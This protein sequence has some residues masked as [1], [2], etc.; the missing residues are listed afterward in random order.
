MNKQYQSVGIVAFVLLG[1]W[2]MESC[3]STQKTT[4]SISVNPVHQ[5]LAPDSVGSIDMNVTFGIPQRYISR[6]SR[7]LITPQLII[8]DTLCREFEPLVV[9][10]PVYAKKQKRRAD[11]DGYQDPY[12]QYRQ[13]VETV[14][15]PFE[16]NYH[17]RFNIPEDT[18]N[19]FVCAVVR[20][21]GCGRCAAL[22][23]L[24]IADISNPVTLIDPIESLDLS[25]I[26]PKFVIRPKLREG[27][28]EALLQFIIN[29]YDINLALGN[30]RRE[31]ERMIRTLEPILTDT[32]A[33]IRTLDIY[34]MASADGP[35]AFNTT[36]ARNRALSAKNWL[37]EELQLKPEIRKLI[38]TD[39]RP[40]GWW[41]VYWAMVADGHSDSLAVKQILT[42]YVQ[43]ND[44]VQEHYIRRL[45]CWP[46]IRRKYLSKDRKVEYTYSYTL[47]SF[48]TDDELKTMYRIRPDAFNEDELLRV[49]VLAESD[50]SKIEVY[51]TLM[52][53]FPQSEVAANNLAV[54]YL[55][56]G[57]P[58]KARQ[59]LQTQQEYS[60]EM[61]ATLAACYI[62]SDDYERAVELLQEVELPEARYNLGLLKARQRKLGEAYE[63]LKDYR[64]VNSAIMALSVGRNAEAQSIMCEL[65]DSS[66]LSEYVRALVAARAGDEKAFRRHIAN[67]CRDEKLQKRALGEADFGKFRYH[68]TLEP[69]H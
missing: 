38:R 43:G 26:E 14:S 8:G 31:M 50:T 36:L 23:T 47:R 11:L 24:L 41:P 65:H 46:D 9:D 60:P 54:L 34:G 12:T 18:Q 4:K 48:T 51:C 17:K 16:L 33:T 39:S 53:Y 44:D 49:A 52:K 40:E 58:E 28:G 22:D 25:W 19:G 64:D 66:P 57:Q 1:A 15:R 5:V 3:A 35:Y 6:R 10:A 13:T 59:T 30:N 20:K 45:S 55:R 68:S 67:A 2:I 37:V 63:L 56:S 27:R 62:Y 61:L 7:L 29:R 21:D 42:R 32:L 69:Q